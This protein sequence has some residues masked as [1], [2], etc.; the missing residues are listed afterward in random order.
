[1]GKAS[2]RRDE[3]LHGTGDETGSSPTLKFSQNSE[4]AALL[5]LVLDNV[6]REG[7]TLK[8]LSERLDVEKPAVHRTL[9]ALRRHGLVTQVGARGPYR[10]GPAALGLGRKTYR[11]SAVAR[12]KLWSPVLVRLGKEFQSSAF[13]L[14]RSGLD[15][16]ITDMYITDNSLKILGDGIGGRLPLGYG[17]GAMAILSAQEPDNLLAITIANESRYRELGIDPDWVRTY[18]QSVHEKGHDFR[19]SAVIHGITAVAMPII[20][21]DGTCA[22]AITVAQD[23]ARMTIETANLVIEKMRSY[24]KEAS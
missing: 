23:T 22:A 4:R 12:I 1:L 2:E 24:I 6:G 15:A 3:Q 14:Q 19:T 21:F 20:E 5:L 8:E 18:S 13:L 11:M 9:L 17:P 7:M 10:L 16:V